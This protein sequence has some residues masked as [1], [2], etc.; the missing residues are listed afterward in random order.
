MNWGVLLRLYTMIA[1]VSAFSLYVFSEQFSSASLA[2]TIVAVATIA[3]VSVIL[4][5]L[6]ALS[7]TWE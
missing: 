5:A 7:E 2:I 1:G 3:L 4:G 6:V